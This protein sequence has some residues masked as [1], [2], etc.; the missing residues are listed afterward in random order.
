M[1]PDE[2]VFFVMLVAEAY[3]LA[4]PAGIYLSIFLTGEDVRS[5]GSGAGGTTNLSRLLAK[6][7]RSGK[8]ALLDFALDAAKS[9]IFPFISY[10]IT[11]D[12][13]AW[14][15]GILGMMC[16]TGNI[17]PLCVPEPHFQ[18]GKGVATFA[19]A[20]I[21]FV[22]VCFRLLNNAWWIWS[23]PVFI[24]LVFLLILKARGREKMVLPS[25]MVISL[26]TCFQVILGIIYPEFRFLGVC[27]AVMGTF[28]LLAHYRNLIS[29]FA[30]AKMPKNPRELHI[31]TV[32]MLKSYWKELDKATRLPQA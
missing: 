7:G 6:H 1:L 31:R 15:P 14:V 21:G 4:V 32:A 17:L 24:G 2:Y 25:A 30:S 12:F 28:S 26:S 11:P 13:T 22:Y 20:E 29:I 23:V 18:G 3:I 5:Q 27:T 8:W 16:M 10:W 9:G 19:G